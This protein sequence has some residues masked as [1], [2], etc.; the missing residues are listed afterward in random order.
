VGH[1][2]RRRVDIYEEPSNSA[3]T[4]IHD[5]RDHSDI[6]YIPRVSIAAVPDE[7]AR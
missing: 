5:I 4:N 1:H 7:E 2:R 6:C 3:A